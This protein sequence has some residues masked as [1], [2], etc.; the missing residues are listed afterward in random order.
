MSMSSGK[1]RD[2][3]EMKNQILKDG[4]I[5]ELIALEDELSDLQ[6]QYGIEER[7]PLWM[8]AG[9]AYYAAKESRTQLHRVN[10]KTYLWLCALAVV[11]ANQFYA[12]HYLRGLFYLA[13]SWTGIPVALGLID[14]MAAVPKEP[15]EDGCI[16][17]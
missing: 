9:D 16:K 4:K 15:D 14:W 6:E 12:K 1:D 8:R 3:A 10:R 5:N 2:K 17:V 13:I 7:K 11:G